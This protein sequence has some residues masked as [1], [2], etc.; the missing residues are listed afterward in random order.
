MRA[1]WEPGLPRFI[2][3]YSPEKDTAVLKDMT[4]ENGIRFHGAVSPG[5]VPKVMAR[6]LAVIHT[7]SFDLEI[8]KRVRFSIS[9]KIPETLMNGPCLIA[10]GPEDVASISY[11]QE[12]GAAYV[13]TRRARLEQGLREILTDTALRGETVSRARKLARE[14][15]SSQNNPANLRKRLEEICREWEKSQ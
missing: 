15:H 7:E 13:I 11:L 12:N 2:D 8:R 10:Y 3:V 14:N 5:D 6:S 9:T 4:L 1:I